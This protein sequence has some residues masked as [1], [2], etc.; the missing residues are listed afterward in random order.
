MPKLGRWLQA[1]RNNGA[2]ATAGTWDA[3]AGFTKLTRPATLPIGAYS[4]PQTVD[5]GPN[6]VATPIAF[7]ASSAA[8]LQVGPQG[9]GETW[10]LDQ[11]YLSTSI[12]QLDAASCSV[13]VGPAAIEGYLFTAN[14][15]GGGAQFSLGGAGL[16]VGDF[17]IAVWSGGTPGAVANLR[18]TGARTALTA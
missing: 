2:A 8:T 17:V 10:S 15:S 7:S 16:Q 6:G 1:Y 3:S 11:C 18:V 9:I 5:I 13:Y 14:L 4:T 12:G